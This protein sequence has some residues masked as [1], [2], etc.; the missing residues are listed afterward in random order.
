MNIFLLNISVDGQFSGVNRHIEMLKENITAGTVHHIEVIFSE[1]NTGI[2][3]N[4][5]M[6]YTG[7]YFPAPEDSRAMEKINDFVFKKTY[8]LF[9]DKTDIILHLHTLNLIGIA[10]K[11][12]DVFG[13]KI[14]THLHC[15][16][17]TLF[18]DANQE[19]YKNI[20]A[21]EIRI[22]SE[23][24]LMSY[25]NADT[26]I[27]V[28]EMA[29]RFVNKISYADTKVVSNAITR[30]E[31]IR[32]KKDNSFNI[33]FAGSMNRNKG[34]PYLLA[35]VKNLVEK[36]YRD[37]RLLV[38]GH[39]TQEMINEYFEKNARMREYV[40]FLGQLP[41]HQLAEYYSSADIGIVPSFHE[42]CS[43]TAIEMA[44]HGVPMIVSDTDGLKEIFTDYKNALKLKIYQTDDKMPALNIDEITDKILTLKNNPELCS[45]LS[46]NVQKL[47]DEKFTIERMIGDI[48]ETYK[49][50]LEPPMVSI[51]MPVFNADQYLKESIT[52][53]LGQTYRNFELIIIDD[54]SSDNSVNIIRSF[55]DERIRLIERIENNLVDALNTGIN[56][57]SGKYIAR[58]DADDIMMPDRLQTQVDV[59]ERN[60]NIS[61]CSSQMVAFDQ[62]KEFL[63]SSGKNGYIN[64]VMFNF[65]EA[66]YIFHPTV[67]LRKKFLVKNNLK[68]EKDYIYA[69]DYKLWTEI[70]KR[71]GMFFI[72]DRPL[73]RYRISPN[74][75][76]YKKSDIQ[77]QTARK[78][79]LE[80]FEYLYRQ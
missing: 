5:D 68:Y 76:S 55:D 29:E 61:I 57:A 60:L 18:L 59:M 15:L 42:Q 72:I 21:K 41:Y 79:R 66:N 17:Y 49:Q 73:I 80:I 3:E 44:M 16:P 14:I 65:L 10:E 8:G 36:G 54:C 19:A 40:T 52:S 39:I 53:V 27:C 43:Y 23:H 74:Q 46:G 67:M 70:A 31:V 9:Q 4:D 20:T 35:A 62:K 50:V 34:L 30:H 38:A 7:I 13:A 28:T 25:T 69:E 78:I 22:S 64:Q 45:M 33:L 11:I 58:F 71:G 47:Y 6:L 2:V 51:V 63:S 56:A 32:N 26:V 48:E 1:K 24:E 75:I 12:K 77:T 37:I